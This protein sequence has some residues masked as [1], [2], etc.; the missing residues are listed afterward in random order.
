[1]TV[2]IDFASTVGKPTKALA[3]ALDE[4][5]TH[6]ARSRRCVV[7]TGAGISVAGGIPDFRSSDGLY[8]LVK[9]KYPHAVVKG[10]DLFDANLFKDATSTSVFYTFVAELKELVNRASVTRAHEFIKSLDD[11]GKL[12]RCYTQNIDGLEPRIGMCAR[13]DL[14]V[15]PPRVKG[16][17]KQEDGANHVRVVQLHGDLDH[18]VCTLCRASFSFEE[19]HRLVFQG[20][21]PPAC[22]SC[23]ETEATRQAAGKRRLGVGTLRPAIVLYNENH[24]KGD[25]IG[26]LVGIDLRR[27]PDMLIVMGTSLKVVGI[28]K[29][30]KDLAKA[31]H[32]SPNGRVVLIN[33]TGVTKEW[34][35]VF[36]Y[37]V[38]GPADAI[39]DHLWKDLDRKEQK[40][41]IEKLTENARP[42]P[43]R[44]LA[45][46]DDISVIAGATIAQDTGFIAAVSSSAALS[47]GVPRVVTP[48][49]VA[50]TKVPRTQAEQVAVSTL[51]RSTKSGARTAD[52]KAKAGGVAARAAPSRAPV[53]AGN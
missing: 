16:K 30:V 21:E 46:D 15:T 40:K 6:L 43:Q 4:L 51:F 52:S 53:V 28:K 2:T 41:A 25:I 17:A 12:M 29:V 22:P 14:A 47:M 35:S 20:G 8:N 50:A 3:D 37:H 1:M 32:A 48:A 34:E 9:Q 18:V 23:V 24:D 5:G 10:K 31:I 42:N 19:E 26:K 36:D 11:R 45:L 13:L 27:K 44:N 39:V 49:A 7:V 33:Q 38:L